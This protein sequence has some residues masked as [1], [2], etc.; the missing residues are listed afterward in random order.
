MRDE[1]FYFEIDESNYLTLYLYP[2]DGSTPTIDEEYNVVGAEVKSYK[3]YSLGVFYEEGFSDM[4]DANLRHE[5]LDANGQPV[6]DDN[7]NTVYEGNLYD[8]DIPAPTETP[9]WVSLLPYAI[10]ILVF[11]VLFFFMMR[12]AGGGSKLNSFGKAR[13]KTL[14][15]SKDKVTFADVA[16]ADEEKQELEEIV[17][18]L[19]EPS[20]FTRLGAKIPHGVLLVGP[21]G[22]GKTLLAKAVAGEAG[23]P[24]YSIS[25]S[26]FVEMYVGVGASR[27][28]DLFETA[29]K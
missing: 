27:V 15:Q 22:T 7:G 16:G 18:F 6:K 14:D 5:V 17:E 21:P 20:K 9:W 4:V 24:F 19:K 12:S 29:K 25:G 8:Y 26:D 1:V 3:F 10:I 28:R 23:V 2:A 11:V 13:T